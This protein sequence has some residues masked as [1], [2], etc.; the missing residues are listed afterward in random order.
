LLL[1]RYTPKELHCLTGC[2]RFCNY[3]QTILTT[4]DGTLINTGKFLS[5]LGTYATIP[6][7]PCGKA[8][9][10]LPVKYL[11]IVH[12]DIAFSNV[13]Q[14]EASNLPL[15]LSVTPHATIGRLAS[16][17][18]NTMTSK[19]PSLLFAMKPASL[20]VSSNAT[21]MKSCLAAC[22]VH[23]STLIIPQLQPVRQGT[24]H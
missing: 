7:A 21:A 20:L 24:N 22:Y 18:S 12:V 15:S 17:L 16:S 9:N 10:R 3:Q 13:S 14:S 11:D 8:I 23:S 1:E 4:K 6:K 5:S 19:W 2:C